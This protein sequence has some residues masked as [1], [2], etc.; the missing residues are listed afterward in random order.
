MKK[1]KGKGTIEDG[2][3]IDKGLLNGNDTW[4]KAFWSRKMRGRLYNA[5][6]WGGR[7][8]MARYLRKTGG[9][10]D[11]VAVDNKMG[12][13]ERYIIRGKTWDVETRWI[14]CAGLCCWDGGCI[15][16]SE[17]IAKGGS[18]NGSSWLPKFQPE[19]PRA[20]GSGHMWHKQKRKLRLKRGKYW[21]L[22]RGPA[23]REGA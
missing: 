7:K 5:S 12:G 13:G 4:S 17:V 15:Q 22:N 10:K 23:W 18:G 11:N 6:S 1:Q 2:W 19:K 14:T 3:C 9:K 16:W 8:S 21:L 20:I